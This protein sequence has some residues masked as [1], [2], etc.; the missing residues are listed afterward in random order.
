M[1]RCENW[2]KINAAYNPPAKARRVL[3]DSCKCAACGA[4]RDT[5][6]MCL[7]S[8]P[9][10]GPRRMQILCEGCAERAAA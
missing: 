10:L 6:R 3:A 4:E 7:V 5:F 8:A 1:P 9:F 2:K